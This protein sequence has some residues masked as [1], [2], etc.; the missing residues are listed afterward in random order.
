MLILSKKS[1]KA[2]SGLKT[3]QGQPSFTLATKSVQLAVTRLGGHLGPVTF[4]LGRRS[5]EPFAVAPWWQ[6]KLA[7]GTPALL[8]VLRGDFFCLPFGGNGTPFRGE[9]HPPH[10]ETAGHRWR[11][12]G[13]D[14]TGGNVTL[15]LAM[16]TKTRPG[17]VEKRITLIPG[18][19]NIYQEHVITGMSGPMCFGHHAMLKFP[20]QPGSGL[21]STSRRILGQVF[22]EP[23]ERPEQRGYSL[24]KPGAVFKDLESVPTITGEKADLSRYPARRGYEDIAI[25]AADP[26]LE[27]AWSAVAFPGEGYVWFSLRD[28]KVLASTL[29]WMSNGG[30]HFP[31]WNG[32]HT[33]VMGIEEITGFFHCGLAE[34]AAPNSLSRR[35]IK[36]HHILDASRPFAVR[37]I[38]GLAAIP[39]DFGR[40]ADIQIHPHRITLLGESGHEVSTP[41]QTTFLREAGNR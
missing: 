12:L 37:S 33:N 41:V 1:S 29:L 23:A 20:N 38:M 30:R 32:R 9:M 28:P 35:G 18:E 4:R 26:H 36:T 15:R 3:I 14:L 17:Q 2:E 16:K 10:G 40:V 34:S 31:P 39:K 27:V 5:V 7:P 25:L 11:D 8:R 22:V 21:L 24:L 19:T 13:I 6:E